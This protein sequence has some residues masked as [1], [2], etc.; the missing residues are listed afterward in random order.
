MLSHCRVIKGAMS[1]SLALST[2]T[3]ASIPT[4]ASTTSLLNLNREQRRSYETATEMAS[5][6]SFARGLFFGV[7][8]GK[9]AYPYPG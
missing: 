9:L 4:A 2:L 8:N 6:V 7:V 3:R 1:R 5:K